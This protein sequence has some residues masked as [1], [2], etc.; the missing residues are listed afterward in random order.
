MSNQILLAVALFNSTDT[1]NLTLSEQGVVLIINPATGGTDHHVHRPAIR[2][3]GHPI[4]LYLIR[5]INDGCELFIDTTRALPGGRLLIECPYYLQRKLFSIN[6]PKDS[7]LSNGLRITIYPPRAT[8]PTFIEYTEPTEGRTAHLK[9]CANDATP[10]GA[11]PQLISIEIDSRSNP[12]ITILENTAPAHNAP[13]L[14][15]RYQILAMSA[16]SS[17]Q[18]NPPI[19]IPLVETYT[20]N[21]PPIPNNVAN[22]A[23][24]NNDRPTTEGP[25]RSQQGTSSSINTPRE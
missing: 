9:I 25:N 20:I 6:L 10:A 21:L 24:E 8:Q 3:A 18:N 5:I 16:D 11:V 15:A 1:P 2:Q 12:V 13:Y 4:N 7:M 14:I 23:P 19:S 17:R 22:P